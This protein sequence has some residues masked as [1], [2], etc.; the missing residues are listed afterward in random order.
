MR[1]LEASCPHRTS[2]YSKG[3]RGSGGD[4]L[5]TRQGQG[6]LGPA[7]SRSF[8]CLRTTP[9]PTTPS[10]SLGAEPHWH[11]NDIHTPTEQLGE[12]G[13]PDL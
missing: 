7:A 9:T 11:A 4:P 6:P 12:Q 5:Y 3:F 8:L 10:P 1:E 2:T 13:I